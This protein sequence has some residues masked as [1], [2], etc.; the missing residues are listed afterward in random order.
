MVINL[1]RL[2]D[3]LLSQGQDSDV[4]PVVLDWPAAPSSLAFLSAGGR[5]ASGSCGPQIRENVIKRARDRSL[6]MWYCNIV[7]VLEVCPL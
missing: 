1:H 2:F 4:T 7:L 3:V 5:G 6:E